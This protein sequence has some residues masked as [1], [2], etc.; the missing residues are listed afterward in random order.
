MIDFSFFLIHVCTIY[1]LQNKGQIYQT[2]VFIVFI[3]APV[4]VMPQGWGWADH[5][6]SDANKIDSL[7][8]GM[9]GCQNPPHSSVFMPTSV[10][11]FY[12]RIPQGWRNISSELPELPILPTPEHHIHWGI[13]HIAFCILS[14][15]GKAGWQRGPYPHYRLPLIFHCPLYYGRHTY[16]SPL[17]TSPSVSIMGILIMNIPILSPLWT[18]PLWISP[19]APL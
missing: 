3:Y 2:F 11:K 7:Q 12:V 16:V 13:T 14:S 5:G 1:I 10:T 15:L 9:V 18:S 4:N 6:D 19:S 8:W 17:W